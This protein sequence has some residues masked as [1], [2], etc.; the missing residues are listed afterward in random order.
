MCQNISFFLVKSFWATFIDIWRFFSG[1]T[2]RGLGIRECKKP[3]NEPSKDKKQQT[4]K[5]RR[6]C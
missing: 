1:H 2:G 3:R 6:R 4:S 5:K